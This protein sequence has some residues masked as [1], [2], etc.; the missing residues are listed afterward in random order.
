VFFTITN[1]ITKLLITAS[2]K[3]RVLFVAQFKVIAEATGNFDA[4]R[5]IE[6]MGVKEVQALKSALASLY[7]KN[8]PKRES[9]KGNGTLF[10]LS[11]K[12]AKIAENTNKAM[13]DNKKSESTADNDAER[14]FKKRSQDGVKN[15]NTSDR[16]KDF[17]TVSEA[18]KS[19]PDFASIL[20]RG[21]SKTSTSTSTSRFAHKVARAADATNTDFE[22]IE[23]STKILDNK[24]QSEL[25]IGAQIE[26]EHKP[27]YNKIKAY[28]EEN[29][30][31]PEEA[32]FE[33][34][35]AEDHISHFAKYYTEGLIPMEKKLSEKDNKE[36][37]PD[38]ESTKEVSDNKE[39][40]VG[41]S[42]EPEV[43]TANKH[44]KN[45][46]QIKAGLDDI[47]IYDN[48]NVIGN[49]YTIINKT[50]ALGYSCS[51]QPYNQGYNVFPI[52]IV[53]TNSEINQL[54][55]KVN[56]EELPDDVKTFVSETVLS[57]ITKSDSESQIK[58]GSTQP[59]AT[60][61]IP[62]STATITGCLPSN[63]TITSSNTSNNMVIAD[64]QQGTQV[65]V[66]DPSGTVKNVTITEV[67]QTPDGKSSY[68]GT[69]DAGAKVVVPEGTDIS[70]TEKTTASKNV[71]A[72]TSDNI[73]NKVRKLVG[74]RTY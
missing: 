65:G 20:N 28:F 39:K 13:Y 58:E 34:W 72:N 25:S 4:V 17:G 29:G 1:S 71:N 59:Q 19:K 46:K 42:E 68:I 62:V 37:E 15:T 50:T 6:D 73:L 12:D 10:G 32:E 64:I 16:K 2:K 14:N 22:N 21:L 18:L 70:M 49:R 74:M 5:E 24:N 23:D 40:E 60:I 36:K 43:A 11:G 26:A 52:D 67:A 63:Y 55:K 8:N 30:E 41:K 31:L 44:L 3:K 47:V 53:N 69:N 66:A 33:T 45:T 57:A 9:E 54:G 27:T 48:G 51:F 38:K 7:E 61:Y 56:Y 35:I